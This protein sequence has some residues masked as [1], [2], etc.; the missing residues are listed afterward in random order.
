MHYSQVTAC[1]VTFSLQLFNDF[2]SINLKCYYDY[3][4]YNGPAAI[5]LVAAILTIQVKIMWLEYY[6]H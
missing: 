6:Y 1:I 4:E 3:P 5:S 2:N